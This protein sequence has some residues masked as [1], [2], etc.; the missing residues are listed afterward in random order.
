MAKK[1]SPDKGKTV[2]W[3]IDEKL[4][5]TWQKQLVSELHALVLETYP[6]AKHCIKWSQPVYETAEGPFVFMKAAKKHVTFGF[7]RGTELDDSEGVLEGSGERMRH[8]KV[9]EK[10]LPNKELLSGMILQAVKLNAEKG[11]PTKKS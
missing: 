11:D 10:D 3:Y 5:E 4:S 7:W 6:E 9:K 8:V 2:A 1:V